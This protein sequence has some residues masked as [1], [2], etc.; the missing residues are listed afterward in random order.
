MVIAFDV[1]GTLFD[2]ND[3]SRLEVI[4]FL[5]ALHKAGH[6]IWIWSGGG[7]NYAIHKCRNIETPVV[8]SA[9]FKTDEVDVCF[10]DQD[11]NLAK[12]NIRI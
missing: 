8:F 2:S 11:V 7:V 12:V 5:G 4:H 10:D 6:E 1:D 3:N 9:K